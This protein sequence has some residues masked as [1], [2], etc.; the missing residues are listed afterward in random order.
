[1]RM[2]YSLKSLS[3]LAEESC[4]ECNSALTVSR[5]E[6]CVC[7]SCGL[8]HE[9]IIYQSMA[10]QSPKS[11]IHSY[12]SKDFNLISKR[13]TLS[14]DTK[15]R[16]SSFLI[17]LSDHFELSRSIL[18]RAL[19]LFSKYYDEHIFKPKQENKKPVHTSLCL[20]VVSLNLAIREAGS[21]IV[22]K[23]LLSYIKERGHR[24]NKNN[25]H[26]ALLKLRVRMPIAE[27]EQYL[28][29]VL[30]ILQSQ[31]PGKQVPKELIVELL[32]LY[33]KYENR[34]PFL[35]AICCVGIAYVFYYD[36]SKYRIAKCFEDHFNSATIYQLMDTLKE[37]ISI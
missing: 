32:R 13:Y 23:D 24:M 9:V 7:K 29:R 37:Q 27:P 3:N 22:F 14:S 28:P 5:D 8:V 20:V 17:S 35:F 18:F 4:D 30:D 10:F 25:F 2:I 11:F 34:N 26:Q 12:V 21:P 33:S 1:M 19:H 15:V 16:W 31:L 36:I 6:F